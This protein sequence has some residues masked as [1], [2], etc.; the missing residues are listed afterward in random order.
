MNILQ[1][2]K[3]EFTTLFIV[4]GI[5]FVTCL[6]ISNII[7]GKLIEVYGMVLPAAVILFPITYIF[8]TLRRPR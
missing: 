3:N 7:A 2:R 5:L 4:L 8:P 6:L 1:E